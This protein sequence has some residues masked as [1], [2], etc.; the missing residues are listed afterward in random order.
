MVV[1]ALGQR[2]ADGAVV[3][4]LDLRPAARGRLDH[5]HFDDLRTD[6]VDVNIGGIRQVKDMVIVGI[7]VLCLHSDWGI[8][9]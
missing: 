8:G 9:Y 6:F 1:D 4:L 2:E 5:L 7:E 3:E